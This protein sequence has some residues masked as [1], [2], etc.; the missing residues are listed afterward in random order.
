MRSADWK[1]IRYFARHED[2][3]QAAK[4]FRGTLDNYNDC[5]IAT[6]HGEQPVFE[7]LFDLRQDP[8]EVHNV[9]GES[10]H[11]ETMATLRAR[12]L[13]LARVAK[14]DDAPPRTLR[15]R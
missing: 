10:Q 1:Y 4:A 11:A 6:L 5:L 12:L 13:Q 14:G 15:N 2:P 7:E 8:G 3:R 9:A